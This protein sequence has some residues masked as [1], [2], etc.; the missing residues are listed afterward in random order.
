MNI[1]AIALDAQVDFLLF[2]DGTCAG[3]AGGWL[4]HKATAR[5]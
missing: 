5:H 1:F 4:A 2:D 3:A